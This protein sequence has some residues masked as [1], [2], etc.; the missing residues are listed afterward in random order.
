MNFELKLSTVEPCEKHTGWV[1]AVLFCDEESVERDTLDVLLHEILPEKRFEH[2]YIKNIIV[3]IRD[4]GAILE[5]QKL[6]K[7]SF[8]IEVNDEDIVRAK[9]FIHNHNHTI[10]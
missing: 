1:E 5:Y 9:A 4:S 3:D 2:I 6:A 10:N 7:S 8:E